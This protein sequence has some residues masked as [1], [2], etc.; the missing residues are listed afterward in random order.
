MRLLESLNFQGC[1]VLSSSDVECHKN[2]LLDL[3]QGLTAQKWMSQSGVALHFKKMLFSNAPSATIPLTFSPLVFTIFLSSSCSFRCTSSCWCNCKSLY[4][5]VVNFQKVRWNIL[6][7][8]WKHAKVLV[9]CMK[10]EVAVDCWET[11]PRQTLHAIYHPKDV[12]TWKLRLFPWETFALW[13]LLR[14]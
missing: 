11:L 13:G 4:I 7:I 1:Y 12:L 6:S 8:A 9:Q 14:I 10:Y 3:S 2:I 5:L